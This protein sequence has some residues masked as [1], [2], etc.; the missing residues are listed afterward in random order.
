MIHKIQI[1]HNDLMVILD[2]TLKLVDYIEKKGDL[3]KITLYNSNNVCDSFV[4]E[5]IM[6]FEYSIPTLMCDLHS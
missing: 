6:Y 2:E 4:Y 5:C 3:M 1:I